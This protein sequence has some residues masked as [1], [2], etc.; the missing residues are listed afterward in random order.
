M[1]FFK[2]TDVYEADAFLAKGWVDLMVVGTG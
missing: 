1:L 2:A